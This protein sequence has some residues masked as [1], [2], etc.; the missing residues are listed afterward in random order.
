MSADS[1]SA[2]DENTDA[3]RASSVSGD[4]GNVDDAI[5]DS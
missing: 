2:D 3:G 4:D 1:V 5:E